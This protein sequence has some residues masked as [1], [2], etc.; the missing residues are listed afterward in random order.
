M[1]GTSTEAE[2]RGPR[3]PG[4]SSPA[5]RAGAT[6][7]PSVLRRLTR[8]GVGVGVGEADSWITR[9][10]HRI[11]A[12][13]QPGHG[14]AIVLCHGFPD[15]HHLLPTA[16]CRYSRATRSLTSIS[17][18]GAE[19]RKRAHYNY[20]FA[21]Q[22][23]DL[24]CGDPGIAPSHVSSSRTTPACP[25]RSTGR[26]TIPAAQPRGHDPLKRLLRPRPRLRTATLAAILALG[27]WPNTAPLGPSPA[28]RDRVR[29]HRA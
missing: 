24:K 26:S 27:Q 13:S 28:R 3:P 14:P 5:A 22:E 19:S 4:W 25:Q 2:R 8:V 11:A 7:A 12:F 16:S 20:T 15:N 21:G 1:I 29:A 10:G 6:R 18:G 17:W 23:Q 9:A